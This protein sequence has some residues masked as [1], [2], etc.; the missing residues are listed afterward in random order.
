MHAAIAACCMTPVLLAANAAC[1]KL[2]APNLFLMKLLL[3]TCV[4][5]TFIA[6]NKVFQSFYQTN[7][8]QAETI[9][10]GF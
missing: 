2:H 10:F 3:A 1:C 6:I 9:Q 7:R 8:R 4:N 5:Y